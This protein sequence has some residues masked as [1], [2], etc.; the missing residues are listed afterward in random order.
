MR[1]VKFTAARHTVTIGVLAVGCSIVQLLWLGVG[2]FLLLPLSR[3]YVRGE[4]LAT[5]VVTDRRGEPLREV[6]SSEYGVNHWVELDQVSL[7]FVEAVIVAEDRRFWRHCGVDLL[8]LVRATLTNLRA[9]RVVSGGSTITQQLV[10]VL[11]HS[12]RRGIAT[13][14]GELLGAIRLELHLSKREIL[15]AYV[16]RVWFGNQLYGID[17]AARTYF[18]RSADRLSLAQACFLAGV[19]RSP[20]ECDPYRHFERCRRRQRWILENLLARRR[21]KL[22]DF[23]AALAE[24]ITP[25]RPRRPFKASH[26]VDFVLSTGLPKGAWRGRERLLRTTLDYRLQQ[27]CEDLVEVHLRQFA[28]YHV[29][30]A[31]VVVLDRAT[32]EVLAMVGSRDYFSPDAGQVNA[33]LSLRQP[34]SALK[35]FVYALAFEQ[36][37]SPAAIVPDL[38][39]HFAELAG[40]FV[41][42]NYDRQFR[43]P[44]SCR[45]ALGSSYNVPAVRLAEELGVDRLL[46]VL[47]QCGLTS[48]RREPGYYG[49]ALSLGVGDVRLLEL[50]N[51]YR[52]LANYGEFS[53]VRVIMSDAEPE[54]GLRTG[55]SQIRV[56]SPQSAYLVTDILCDNQARAPAFGQFSCLSLPFPC[57]VKT[58]TSKDYR[59]NWAVGY[60]RDYVVG[61]W[62]GNFDGSPMHRVSGVTGAGPLFR[63][64]MLAAQTRSP[65]GFDLPPGIVL[66]AVCPKSGLIP[67][68][69]C[70]AAVQEKFIASRLPR[71]TC[72]VHLLIQDKVYEV[73]PPEYWA[74]MADNGL[75]LPP[76]T[77]LT[78]TQAR[79][80]CSQPVVLFPDEGDVFKIDPDLS[81]EFQAVLFRAV[82]PAGATEARWI[83]DERELAVVGPPYACFW[84][85]EPGKHRL[86]LLAAGHTS[87]EVSFLVLP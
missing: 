83:L 16:N 3:S 23:E 80:V 6:C 8:A 86:R 82:V 60:T 13:K 24:S 56:F 74:W 7:W 78:Q 51:A 37:K 81:R 76:V 68:P 54:T 34:G 40:D 57:A 46:T 64:V 30:N 14:L 17:A 59:D 50:V 48:L 36:E 38:P 21:I 42:R 67:G 28:S 70:P 33:C 29:T 66:C 69:H 39:G 10:R 20:G 41:P 44:V 52:V 49:L 9:G 12:G 35:P 72:S 53:E 5:L 1:R 31:A 55:G 19:L 26:F 85:L 63:D 84:R 79:T 32:G 25:C 73:Y 77:G 11:R 15:E 58:G 75:P 61:V 4:Q 43:G 2:L 87:E 22:S 65:S 71:E 45:V 47:R 18:N 62:V 27:Q